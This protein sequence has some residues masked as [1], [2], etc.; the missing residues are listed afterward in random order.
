MIHEL[1]PDDALDFLGRHVAL[2]EQ[3]GQYTVLA[4]MAM[5][6]GLQLLRSGDVIGA[7]ASLA[8]AVTTAAERCPTYIGQN[9]NTTIAITMREWPRTATTMLGGL[10]RW[11]RDRQQIGTTLETE[12]ELHYE[13]RLQLSLGDDFG[14]CHER[15]AELSEAELVRVLLAAL[16]AIEGGTM[17]DD[18]IDTLVT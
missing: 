7:S 8:L 2:T 9:A 14:R 5:F 16:H 6:H 1:Q 3:I 12:A 15:G 4:H 10:E 13:R 17:S 18:V 11:R